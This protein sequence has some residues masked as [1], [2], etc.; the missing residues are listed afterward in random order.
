MSNKPTAMAQKRHELLSDIEDHV[1]AVI[2]EHGV[3]A[4]I[5]EQAGAAVVDHLS[6]TWAGSCVTFPKDFRWRIT[7]RDLEILGKF[8]GNNHHALAVE[9]GM[10]ESAIYKLLK[11]IQDR[12]FDRDQHKIDFGDGL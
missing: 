11:R 3:E 5:A 8:K 7:Q 9:Y 12:K 6:N 4:K 2:E 1:K 10:G